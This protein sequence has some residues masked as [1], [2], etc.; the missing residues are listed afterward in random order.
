MDF[1]DILLKKRN[2][3][4]LT[5]QQIE[6]FVKGVTE[7]TIPDYQISSFLMAVYFQSLDIEETAQLTLAMAKS[8]EML[9]LSNIEGFKTDKH[10]TGGVADT[11]T[12]ILAPLVAS[13]GVPVV[14]MSGRGLGF[15]GG[16]IDK[17]E[18][19]PHFQTEVTQKQALQWAKQSNIVIMGQS[20][21]LTPADQ[22]LYALRDVTAT[23]ESIPLIASSIMSK[24]I[25]SGAD[26]IVLDVK[27]GNGAFMK[28]LEQA[29]Q[30]GKC[31][32]DMGRHVGR[33]VTVVISSMS[34]PL[35]NNI[36]NRLEVIEAIETLKGN[37]KGDLL[38]VSITLGAYMLLQANKVQ[39]VQQGK[40]LLLQNIEN[41]KGLLKFEE[42]LKQQYGDSNIIYDY[43]ILALSD[44]KLCLK[45]QQQGYISAMDT[46]TIGRASQQTG[47]GRK[48][49]TDSIDFGAGIIMKKRI[50]DSVQKGEVIAEIYSSNEQ[51][52]QSALEL[53]QYAVTIADTPPISTPLILDIIS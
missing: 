4:K 5:K 46:E 1:L 31:M 22:K 50:G 49:K 24:K 48:Q 27:C 37:V 30:L 15:S 25:A 36:G 32:A 3:Q 41:G 14:K 40:Q 28:T 7:S 12:L 19:I 20:K 11:T 47:A 45:A 51:K 38:E 29:Q 2:G 21:N 39:T 9:D 35:G 26:G 16:T 6:Y 8:G 13:V 42:L 52:C 43:S 23:V 18:S 34:Q 53:L 17:L 33:K 10:S 44:F